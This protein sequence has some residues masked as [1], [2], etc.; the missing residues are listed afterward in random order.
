MRMNP[1]A[2]PCTSPALTRTPRGVRHSLTRILF[3]LLLAFAAVTGSQFSPVSA[4][5]AG[6]PHAAALQASQSELIQLTPNVAAAASHQRWDGPLKFYLRV[7]STKQHPQPT[8]RFLLIVPISPFVVGSMTDT[9]FANEWNWSILEV[10]TDSGR[11]LL[12]NNGKCLQIGS[13]GNLA[14]AACNSGNSREQWEINSYVFR[15][16][17][18]HQ[19]LRDAGEGG[20]HFV[21]AIAHTCNPND[22]AFQVHLAGVA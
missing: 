10:G 5:A 11:Y 9:R 4:A 14:G 20:P 7:G 12:R 18:T 17:R 8:N 16:V 3:T 2:R 15:N 19:C 1:I 21:R 6:T 22:A 13:N